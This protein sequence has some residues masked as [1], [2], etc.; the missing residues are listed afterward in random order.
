MEAARQEAAQH[1]LGAWVLMDYQPEMPLEPM[2]ASLLSAQFGTM[3]VEFDGQTLNATG[4]GVNV[5]RPYRVTQAS[6]NR[7]TAVVYDQGVAYD[8]V[9][10]FRG[11][12]FWFVA[13]ST[14]WRGHGVLRR[15]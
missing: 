4:T 2:F 1:L 3:V 13:Q 15:R 8:V 6:F 14:P 9:G 7:V 12:E 10:E 5:Q 11:N